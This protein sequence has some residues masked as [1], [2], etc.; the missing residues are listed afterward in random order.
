MASPEIVSFRQQSAPTTHDSGN[1][2]LTDSI[3]STVQAALAN[4][5]AYKDPIVQINAP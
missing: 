3:K 4:L 5:A 1:S 2:P